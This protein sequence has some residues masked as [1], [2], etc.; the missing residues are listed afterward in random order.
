MKKLIK[1]ILRF[2]FIIFLT[3]IVFLSVK[4]LIHA[5]FPPTHDGEY[6]VIRFYQFDKAIHDGDFY[7]RWAKDLNNGY[8]VPLFNYVYPFPNYAAS[9]FH[10]FGASFIDAFK[11][12]LIFATLIGVIFFYLWTKLYFD[13]SA[14]V[15]A[16]V[17]YCFT[18][19]RFV[20]IYVRGSVG[21]VWALAWFP[22]FLWAITILIKNK[23]T[24]YVIWSGIFFALTIFSHNILGLMFA[25]FG[26][27]YVLFCIWIFKARKRLAYLTFFSF[28][29]GLCLSA[30]FW[31]PALIETRFVQNLQIYNVN[32]HFAEIYQLIIPSW[33]TGFSEQALGNQ[34]SLQIGIA[35]LIAV[36][37]GLILLIRT[38]YI[39]FIAWFIIVV[40]LIL[41]IS[42]PIW[43]AIPILNYFQFPW[44]FL[45]LIM[46]LSAFITGA[47]IDKITRKKLKLI[48]SSIFIFLSVILS[49]SYT[50]PAYY[51]N[52]ND[53]HYLNRDN[54]IHGTNSPGDLFNT[55]WINKKPSIKE[56]RVEI[57]KGKGEINVIDSKTSNLKFTIKND[58]EV[59]VLVNIAYFPGWELKIDEKKTMLKKTNQGAMS[60]SV[61]KG[62]HSVEI[63]FGDTIIRRIGAA[64]SLLSIILCIGFFLKKKLKI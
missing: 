18:P 39:F 33:G 30:V 60:F 64:I 36:F 43:H 29:L 34:M 61:S 11:L 27:F 26:F 12:N 31:L 9:F 38:R 51:H 10:I 22:A 35:N 46:V 62:K 4:P 40:F 13:S 42:K 1:Q 24:N 2:K 45:S 48:V 53:S 47:V 59:E 14:A 28:I 58:T 57:A 17:F 25:G 3:F 44:R 54:F 32:E 20:D 5:G 21:E 52:R 7:P 23:K 15:T 37:L 6:H 56:K 16:A 19:Y 8:G 41:G 63:Q 50:Y 49:I 55:V